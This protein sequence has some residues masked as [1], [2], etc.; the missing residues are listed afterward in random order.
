MAAT[1]ATAVGELR[2]SVT[3]DKA[4]CT[5]PIVLRNIS[6]DPVFGAVNV[7]LDI[8]GDL[9]EHNQI[10]PC[11]PARGSGTRS[12]VL[13]AQRDSHCRLDPQ[14]PLGHRFHFGS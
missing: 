3:N 6:T 4:K 13:E 5:Q 1:A 14:L 8:Q 2:Y 11:R 10:L 9:N 7:T 12:L